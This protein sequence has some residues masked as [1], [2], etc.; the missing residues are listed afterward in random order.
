MID[1][2]WEWRREAFS[3]TIIQV[4]DNSNERRR[5]HLHCCWRDLGSHVQCVLV[6]TCSTKESWEIVNWILEGGTGICRRAWSYF[7]VKQLTPHFFLN[8]RKPESSRRE[9]QLLIE[10]WVKGLL[11]CVPRLHFLFLTHECTH[12]CIHTPTHQ[13]FKSAAVSLVGEFPVEMTM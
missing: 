11:S 12:T 6:C 9:T 5:K 8:G 3:E 7:E 10:I 13:R 1:Q 4:S 2:I